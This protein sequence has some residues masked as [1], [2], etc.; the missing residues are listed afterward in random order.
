MTEISKWHF[1]FSACFF[2]YQNY[3]PGI[4]R[5]THRTTGRHEY[6]LDV[7]PELTAIER[8]S[9]VYPRGLKYLVLS[10]LVAMTQFKNI[11]NVSLWT[12]AIILMHCL[13]RFH[14][15]QQRTTKEIVKRYSE[16]RVKY[17]RLDRSTNQDIA[18]HHKTKPEGNPADQC[19]I[20]VNMTETMSPERQR[21]EDSIR[22][23]HIL[24]PPK[25]CPP[26][27][28]FFRNGTLP[29]TALVSPPGAGNTWTRHLIQVAT[30]DNIV[31]LPHLNSS[32]N[33]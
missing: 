15:N 2:F 25:L 29:R 23:S 6:L 17:D 4:L 21:R 5:D 30:G 27:K 13:T 33:E 3:R 11:C 10:R 9:T 1:H 19:G 18:V 20:F 14:L 24:T 31:L 28:D 12:L 26:T 22:R 16:S 7:R 8:T 32:R